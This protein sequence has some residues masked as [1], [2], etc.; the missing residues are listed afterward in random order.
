MSQ[1]K[2]DG[3]C[4]IESCDGHYWFDVGEESGLPTTI[5]RSGCDHLLEQCTQCK[6]LH[7]ERNMTH[8]Q[9]AIETVDSSPGS[10]KDVWLCKSCFTYSTVIELVPPK[11]LDRNYSGWWK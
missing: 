5:Y 2:A 4:P 7:A 3:K 1:R 11:T 9:W 6:N 8:F 10:W